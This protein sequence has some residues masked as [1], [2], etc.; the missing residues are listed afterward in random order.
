[1]LAL[2]DSPMNIHMDVGGVTIVLRGFRPGR[3]PHHALQALRMHIVTKKVS[4]VL[5]TPDGGTPD[6]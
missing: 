6:R 5:A 1:M 4:H 3:N 2:C